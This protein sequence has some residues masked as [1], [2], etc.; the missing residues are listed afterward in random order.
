MN[1]KPE[2]IVGLL[3]R[4]TVVFL[5]VI[6]FCHVCDLL[7]SAQKAAAFSASYL[8]S[9][10]ISTSPASSTDGL[11]ADTDERV[12]LSPEA[13][14]A[15]DN[16]NP[17]QVSDDSDASQI[18]EEAKELLNAMTLEEK[19]YQLFL[20]TP[21]Q[22][23]GIS[24]PVTKAGST[25]KQALLDRPVGGIIYFADNLQTREQVLEM[26]CNSQQYSKTGLFIAVDEEGGSVSR[27]GRNEALGTTAFPA[28]GTLKTT[29]DA[30][31]AGLTIGTDLRGLGFNLD[32]AP[33]AD[34][35]SNQANPIIGTRAFSSDPETAAEMV[36]AC[37]TGFT[38]AN[39]LCTLKHWPG[40]GDTAGDSHAGSAETDK[41]LDEMEAC[42]FLPFQSGIQA[43][44]PFVMVGH[45]N[46]PAVT[47]E[48]IPASLSSVMVEELLR[49]ALGFGGIIITD[50]MQMKAIT[51]VY[52]SGDAA[53]AALQAG[54]DMLLM[55]ADLDAAA[56]GILTAIQSGVL[57]E[58]RIDESVLRILSVKL[59]S[60]IC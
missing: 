15:D 59:A 54:A 31:Q 7:A 1:M 34:V 8:D 23:T 5:L 26:I 29:D 9:E 2:A 6:D 27:V 56:A 44:A 10:N 46:C 17:E 4:L 53:V 52:S 57:E 35:N 40:H 32:F 47:G 51:N 60:G 12:V 14:V 41:T 38:D 13:S 58:T 19:V 37:V 21:E 28:M 3:L 50:S 25:T 55:P 49:K 30:Y 45:I 24:G 39:M 11:S 43:G 48:D 42:E 33:I 20:V 18:A 22:L 16:S 36:F